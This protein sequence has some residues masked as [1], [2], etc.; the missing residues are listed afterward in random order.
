MPTY[1]YACDKCG[2]RFEQ[3]QSM[4]DKAL[5]TCPKCKAKKLRR[6][7]GAGAGLI[8]KGSGFYQ[9]D[10]RSSSYESGKKADTPSTTTDKPAAGGGGCGKA[11]CGSGGCQSPAK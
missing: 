3:F 2:H 6:L 9:T 11:D 7:I 10:Y 4:K 1:D 5:S 8:F